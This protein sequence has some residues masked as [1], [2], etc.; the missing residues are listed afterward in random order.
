MI[1]IEIFVFIKQSQE[2]CFHLKVVSGLKVVFVTG[3]ERFYIR[4]I[5]L[6][7]AVHR[8]NQSSV[9]H[10]LR[11]GKKPWPVTMA[12][13]PPKNK[14]LRTPASCLSRLWRLDPT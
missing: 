10:S 7:Q 4:S 2:F 8:T 12:T 5:Q 14:K 3:E 11:V 1:N 13:D 9:S 6:R